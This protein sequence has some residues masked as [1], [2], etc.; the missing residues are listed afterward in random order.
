MRPQVLEMLKD[1]IFKMSYAIAILN[2]SMMKN[3]EYEKAKIQQFLKSRSKRR[4]TNHKM[5]KNLI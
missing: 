2:Q 1:L 5:V 3:Y 4:L